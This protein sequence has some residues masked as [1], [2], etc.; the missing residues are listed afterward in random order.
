MNAASW[1]LN[2][3]AGW[4]MPAVITW[5]TAW[6]LAWALSVAAAPLWVVLVLPTALGAFAALLPAVAATSWRR[7]F[8]AAGFPM[9]VLAMDWM[10]G[11]GG[12]LTAWLWLAPLVVLLLA[13]PRRAWRDAPVFPTPR[14]ALSELSKHVRLPAGARVLDAGCGMGDG[15]IE[16]QRALPSARIEG[17]EWS[18]LWRFV[19]AWRCPWAT[20]RQGDMWA[21][22]WS[23]FDVVYLFQ[24]PETMPRA[25][26]KATREMRPG[27]WLISLE[28]E[29]R[30]APGQAWRPT[31]SWTLDG[32]RTVWLYRLGGAH[33]QASESPD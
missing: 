31:A 5:L 22:D 27:C 3:A 25:M 33:T 20:V 2:R 32:R 6:G 23:D 10:P 15:L 16:L 28:F 21:D 8:V 24:R 9:S 29:A 13:Y 18:A 12:A 11:Q 7:V 19:S 30:D 4:P 1:L 26:A 14:G 17:V